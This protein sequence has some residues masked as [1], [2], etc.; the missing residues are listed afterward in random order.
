[1]T[2]YATM[3][4]HNLG[5]LPTPKHENQ[6]SLSF[7]DFAFDEDILWNRFMRKPILIYFYT[8][9]FLIFGVV[10]AAVVVALIDVKVVVFVVFVVLVFI[11]IT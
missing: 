8:Q 7:T 1:M 10:F 5:T 3:F 9:H 11:I 2:E 4:L 6:G